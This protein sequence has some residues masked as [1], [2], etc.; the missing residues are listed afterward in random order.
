MTRISCISLLGWKLLKQIKQLVRHHLEFKT[1]QQSDD[2]IKSKM[3][4]ALEFKCS[5]KLAKN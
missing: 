4:A 1:K 5:L 2:A 3:A